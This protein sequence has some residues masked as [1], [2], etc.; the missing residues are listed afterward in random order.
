MQRSCTPYAPL[1]QAASVTGVHHTPLVSLVY[2]TRVTARSAGV[3]H[4][5]HCCKP[6]S[7]H[8]HHTRHCCKPL[9]S[10][11]YT[12]RR[13]CHCCHAPLLTALVYTTPH[14]PLLQAMQRWCTPHCC[15]PCSADVHHTSHC[16]QRW[17]TPH[18]PLM[19]AMQRWC[20]PHAPLLAAALVY[21]TCPT[22]ASQAT[23]LQC[24]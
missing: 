19:Q 23:L 18:A 1:L 22:A 14:A 24:C 13:W 12:T 15:K 10:L 4:T 5:R 7:A 6:C 16:W 21:T 9:V 20:T 2:T 17:C 11:V 8:V 3:H